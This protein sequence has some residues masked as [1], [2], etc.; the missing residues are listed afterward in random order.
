MAQALLDY[1]QTLLAARASWEA[2]EEGEPPVPP[3]EQ[4]EQL[5]SLGYI[6]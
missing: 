6:Q 4:I 5:S 1:K 2:E 3:E